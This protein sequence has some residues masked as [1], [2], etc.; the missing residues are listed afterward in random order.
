MAFTTFDT[1]KPAGTD[2]P[3]AGDDR[4]REL[5]AAIQERLA[6]DH[7]MPASGTT[8]DNADTGEH[9]KVTL[10]QQT[11]APVP[12]TDKGAL[13]TL[14]AS[15]IAELH[16]KDEGNYIKQLTVRDTVN[17][18]QCLNIEAKD[19]EKA[20][21]AIVDDVT[22]EQTA[23]KLNVKN[24][25]IS[26]TKL[27]TNAV[28]ADKLASDAVVNA[29]VAAGAA[30][31]LSKLAA[32]SARIAVGKYTGDGGSAHSITTTDG[33][34]AIGFQPIF[35]VIWYQSSGAGAAIVFKTNQDGAYTKI[36]GGDAHYLTGI[37]TSLDAD[38][39]TLNTSGYANGNGI[40]YTFIAF[41]V[42]A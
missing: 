42:N 21:T 41:G 15:S 17:A 19:I 34:T 39:F 24:A 38:G 3:S 36:S 1:S 14:E 29:S 26:A 27:A 13:Y 35:L 7:Y 8:F 12:G 11:S 31:A 30:I 33:A 20:G 23:G 25:G 6:V 4:I 2:D 16:F 22:I 37:V 18:K 28:T 9:K 5:K 40:T 32:G 10:R